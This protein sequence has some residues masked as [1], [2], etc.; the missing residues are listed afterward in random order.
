V[1]DVET[2]HHTI[3]NSYPLFFGVE[4][5]EA[6]LCPTGPNH[7]LM[8]LLRKL[9]GMSFPQGELSSSVREGLLALAVYAAIERTWPEQKESALQEIHCA[10]PMWPRFLKVY[11]QSDSR[12]FP[13]AIATLRT[14]F[15]G[16]GMTE[17]KLE[18]MLVKM[19][20][21]LTDKDWSKELMWVSD[22]ST[23]RHRGTE[24]GPPPGLLDY[25]LNTNDVDS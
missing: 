25:A 23:K 21:Q 5:I 16:D 19:I 1:F 3:R 24:D 13:H 17:N 7:S 15:G 12:V 4:N 14:K 9:A 11:S 8:V 10:S 18:L 2:E 20:S 6:I 22:S